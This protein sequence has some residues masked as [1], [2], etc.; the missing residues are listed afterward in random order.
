MS[1][2]GE[3][4]RKTR[5][6]LKLSIG[7]VQKLTG[8]S[9]AHIGKIERGESSPTLDM[10]QKLANAYNTTISDMIGET[11]PAIRKSAMLL[12]QLEKE[13]IVI[14]LRIIRRLIKK[15]PEE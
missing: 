9:H 7:D 5:K 2:A 14:I 12:R 13:D 8:I 1:A 3:N 4:I 6:R 10:L 11:H 15:K